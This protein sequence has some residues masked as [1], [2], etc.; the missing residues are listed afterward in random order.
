MGRDDMEDGL[1]ALGG[2]EPEEGART[3]TWRWAAAAALLLAAGTAWRLRRVPPEAAPPSAQAVRGHPEIHPGRGV[4]VLQDAEG[5]LAPRWEPGGRLVLEKGSGT[6]WVDLPRGVAVSVPLESG[7]AKAEGAAFAVSLEPV[8]AS[9]SRWPV[10]ALAAG[11]REPRIAVFRGTLVW[12]PRDGK[13]LVL[14][15]G[16]VLSGGKAVRDPDQARS[17]GGLARAWAARAW[18]S[19]GAPKAPGGKGMH[20]IRAQAVL[21]PA[22]EMEARLR[23][24]LPEGGAGLVYE[25]E[26]RRPICLLPADGAWHVLR[27]LVSPSGV[28]LW[29]D[30]RLAQVLPPGAVARAATFETG[31]AGAGLAYWESGLDVEGW[32]WRPL[33]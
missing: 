20:A 21:P 1:W 27:V 25:A 24:T 3:L 16:E 30:G 28:E 5:T 4:V 12:E 13:P 32:R 31:L 2:H 17:L 22:Y 19:L 14:S 9:S 26:G 15:E 6:F 33:P 11:P 29:V 23:C 7:T 10:E 18:R 8:R